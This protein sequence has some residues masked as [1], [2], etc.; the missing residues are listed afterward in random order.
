MGRGIIVHLVN[1]FEKY[2]LRENC[3]AISGT[4][5]QLL[6]LVVS[7]TN[8]NRNKLVLFLE[9]ISTVSGKINRNKLVTNRNKLA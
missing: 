2:H 5:L 9:Q 4:Q 8:S 1:S 7:N 3:F 6:L